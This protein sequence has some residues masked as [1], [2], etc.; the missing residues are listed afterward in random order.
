MRMEILEFPDERLR[1]VSEPVTQF[2][3]LEALVEDMFETMYD[4]PGVGLAAIQVNRPIRLMV[5]DV[6]PEGKPQPLVF[7]NPEILSMDSEISWEEGCLSVPG[8]TAPVQRYERL[9][10]R[11]QDI[12]AETFEMD[13]E[14]LLAIAVQHEIDHLNGVLFIDHLSRLRRQMFLKKHRKLVARQLRA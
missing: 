14:G 2:D 3:N 13:T 10:V 4:A 11:A 1:Q 8:F 12:H 6:Q 9:R 5:T 7:V